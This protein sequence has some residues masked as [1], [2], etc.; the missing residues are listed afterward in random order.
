MDIAQFMQQVIGAMTGRGGGPNV[1]GGDYVFSN[2]GFDQVMS[3][4]LEQLGTMGSVPPLNKEAL[5][6]L[7]TTTPPQQVLDANESCIICFETYKPDDQCKKLPCEHLFHTDCISKWLSMHGNCPICRDDLSKK[8][9]PASNSGAGGSSSSGN[10]TSNPGGGTAPAGTA[11]STNQQHSA[12]GN[13]NCTL[14]FM[15]GSGHKMQIADVFR[16]FRI[17]SA[18]HQFPVPAIQ[19]CRFCC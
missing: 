15:N 10:A 7:P 1:F 14:S 9:N 6:K 18:F 19:Q 3:Q 11:A 4:L 17:Y 12:G 2:E 8:Y 5:D 16:L 13:P